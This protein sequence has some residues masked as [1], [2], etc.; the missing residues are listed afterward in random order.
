MDLLEISVMCIGG[1][2]SVLC[3][4]FWNDK[5][6]ASD[7]ILSLTEKYSSLQSTIQRLVE[8]DELK[9]I[10]TKIQH[11]TTQ[12][13]VKEL[14][15]E[16]IEPLRQDQKEIKA[17]LKEVLSLI[18]TFAR[19]LAVANAKGGASHANSTRS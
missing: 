5:K 2:C 9:E 18:N 11:F 14:I 10:E 7:Q 3:V 16:Y 8:K 17:D 19:E 12:A 4:W 15:K 1:L 6:V 13:E